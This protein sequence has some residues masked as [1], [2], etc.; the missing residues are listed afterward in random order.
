MWIL[1][2]LWIQS[3]C[4]AGWHL[5]IGTDA[6]KGILGCLTIHLPLQ[7]L[8][9]EIKAQCVLSQEGSHPA[10]GGGRALLVLESFLTWLRWSRL[11]PK[12]WYSRTRR[13][14]AT[15]WARV[16]LGHT[17]LRVSS[18][19]KLFTPPDVMLPCPVQIQAGKAG[20]GLWMPI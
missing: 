2:L 3:G 7:L 20:H 13:Y 4:C 1:R 11:K 5:S 8:T 16:K 15:L 10:L 6:Q 18:G 12:T 19:L 14:V 9:R 17:G